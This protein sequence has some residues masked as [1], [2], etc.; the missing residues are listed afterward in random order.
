MEEVAFGSK[1]I[2]SLA[3]LRLLSVAAMATIH[4]ALFIGRVFV[5]THIAQDH[6]KTPHSDHKKL[7]DDKK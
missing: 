6:H 4:I 3:A 2:N 1:G 7:A 5:L